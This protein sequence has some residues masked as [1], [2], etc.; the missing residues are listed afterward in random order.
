MKTQLSGGFVSRLATAEKLHSVG[1]LAGDND[2]MN[3]I[4]GKKTNHFE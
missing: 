3:R 4:E 2:Q 1:H